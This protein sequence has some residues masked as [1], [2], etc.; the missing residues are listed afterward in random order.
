MWFGFAKKWLHTLIPITCI[1]INGFVLFPF[2]SSQNEY[3]P[4]TE[5]TLS[6]LHLN[7]NKGL[8]DLS[9]VGTFH[10]DIVFL[11]EATPEL[12]TKL[13]ASLPNY[14][15][16]FSHPLSNTHGSALLVR[17]DA[18]LDILAPQVHH[19]PETNA[20]PLISAQTHLDDIPIRLL[21]F[22]A[23]RPHHPHADSYQQIEFDAVA[24][25]AAERIEA[26]EEL[27]MIG[28][29]NATPWSVRF[30]RFLDR[31]QTKDSMLGFGLQNSWVPTLPLWVGLPIDHAAISDGL[32]VID[33]QTAPVENS[34]HGLLYLQIA[35]TGS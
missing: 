1:I 19:L 6:I 27:I 30:K 13:E 24:D 10:A 3:T 22:H 20:R 17:T 15:I 18:D 29:F 16:A 9:A 8:A 12:M 7:T 26:E 14:R 31:S 21:S 34:D 2:F 23:I 25:W 11:Q 5:S 28:D 4:Q 32:I 33:R 35:L